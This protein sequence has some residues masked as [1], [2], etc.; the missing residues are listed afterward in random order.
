MS[1]NSEIWKAAAISLEDLENVDLLSSEEYESFLA[2]PGQTLVN[3]ALSKDESHINPALVCLAKTTIRETRDDPFRYPIEWSSFDEDL[4]HVLECMVARHGLSFSEIKRFGAFY[5]SLGVLVSLLLEQHLIPPSPPDQN[6]LY[7]NQ[8]VSSAESPGL[9]RPASRFFFKKS[10]LPSQMLSIVPIQHKTQKDQMA[11]AYCQMN[12]TSIGKTHFDFG[13]SNARVSILVVY[14]NEGFVVEKNAFPPPFVHKI[15]DFSKIS[16]S[17][18]ISLAIDLLFG[19]E[20]DKFE[21]SKMLSEMVTSTKEVSDS[22]NTRDGRELFHGRSIGRLGK[23][24]R[25]SFGLYVAETEDGD[26]SSAK[27]MISPSST[28]PSVASSLRAPQPNQP[29]FKK[30][31]LHDDAG[32]PV[33]IT[34][35][36]NEQP[37]PTKRPIFV[38]AGHVAPH[39]H[40]I[41]APGG[42]DVGLQ[43]NDYWKRGAFTD[44]Q[45]VARIM[46]SVRE[47]GNPIISKMGTSPRGFREDWSVCESLVAE[48]EAKNGF[49]R[50]LAVQ[51][52]ARLSKMIDQDDADYLVDIAGSEDAGLDTSV[53]TKVA[54]HGATTKVTGGIVNFAGFDYH[55]YMKDSSVG[56]DKSVPERLKDPMCTL[57]VIMPTGSDPV[58]ATSGDS[59]S[60]VFKLRWRK[61]GTPELIFCGL[62]VSAL[63]AENA[64]MMIPQSELWKQ[65]E[66]GTGKKYKVVA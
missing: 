45:A 3:I 61:D 16:I 18:P 28:T 42:T 22:T 38:T 27:K 57:Q 41:Q 1:A 7:T 56:A 31:N 49:D 4:R 63:T 58:F 35:R 39:P 10:W 12:E 29:V 36:V 24:G 59:G 48:E 25:G 50:K 34:D 32:S 46:E 13:Y 53:P 64:G 54:K 8:L 19:E 15:E 14:T 66:E 23:L 20:T 52:L 17:D 55:Q 30:M 44:E 47:V 51:I 65:L 43:L 5:S 6:E 40:V 33:E 11:D 2:N 21:R 62:L 37:F 26:G 9:S 60:A